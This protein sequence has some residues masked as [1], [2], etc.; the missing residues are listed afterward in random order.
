MMH[1]GSNLGNDVGR[2]ESTGGSGRNAPEPPRLDS[3]GKVHGEIPDHV[4]DGWTREQLE[5]LQD[6]LQT[7]IRTRQAEQRRLGEDGPHRRRINEEIQLL[8]Q[9]QKKLG[10]S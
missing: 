7:S 4:P 10:G 5:E 2:L 9:V 3:T 8:R 6:D 1:G